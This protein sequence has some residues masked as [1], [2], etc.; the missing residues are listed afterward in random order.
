M[1][2]KR[3]RRATPIVAVAAILLSACGGT[4]ATT[5]AATTATTMMMEEEHTEFAF[6]EPA[7]PS[8]ASR[9][10]E[11][12]AGDDLRFN[13]S[14]LTVAAG[15]TVTFRIVNNGQLPHDFTLGDQA[16]QDEHEA[17]MAETAGMTMPDEANAIVVAAGETRELTWRFAEPGTILM[18]CHVPGHY[19]AGM[20]GEITVEP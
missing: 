4:T 2:S 19:A 1:I 11:I 14:A 16:T 9:T 7:E 20:K 17:E 5:T 8:E 6:G 18:G 3:I 12:L 10:V 13:P 15:E